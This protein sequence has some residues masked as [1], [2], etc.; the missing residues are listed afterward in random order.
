GRDRRH[1]GGPDPR[2]RRSDAAPSREEIQGRAGGEGGPARRGN[3]EPIVTEPCLYHVATLGCKL[4]QFDSAT[5]EAGL[6]AL[7]MSPTSD[8]S[9]ARPGLGTPPTAPSA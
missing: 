9:R 6:A 7:G 8:P 3:P 4:N 5:L 1:A 2:H